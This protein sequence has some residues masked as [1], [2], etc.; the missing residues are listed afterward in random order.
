M[1][2][3]NAL[4]LISMQI[5]NHDKESPHCQSLTL[6]NVPTVAFLFV[7]IPPLYA[8]LLLIHGLNLRRAK[9]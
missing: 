1:L 7:M 2:I 9:D 5:F 4:K 6:A 3:F 8:L